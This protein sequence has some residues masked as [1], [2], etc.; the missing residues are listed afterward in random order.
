MKLRY[1]HYLLQQLD[2]LQDPQNPYRQHLTFVGAGAGIGAFYG[3]L[4]TKMIYD[5]PVNYA[6]ANAVDYAV[7]G[8][9]LSLSCTIFHTFKNPLDDDVV[10]WK[11]LK[12]VISLFSALLAIHAVNTIYTPDENIAATEHFKVL[13]K[14]FVQLRQLK[15]AIAAETIVY[16]IGKS[17]S[18]ADSADYDRLKFLVTRD[19][20]PMTPVVIKFVASSGIADEDLNARLQP[21]TLETY[22]DFK[23]AYDCLCNAATN[24]SKV[25]N[26]SLAKEIN[27]FAALVN[28]SRVD[29]KVTIHPL[30]NPE[31]RQS[32]GFGAQQPWPQP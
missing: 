26:G 29:N 9:I 16:Q 27:D 28:Q 13:K 4:N 1:S 2:A 7:K 6:I 31:R 3:S 23:T 18:P 32:R 21:L 22:R 19:A 17:T 30:I 11:I 20:Q 12:S 24:L 14:S 15:Q 5:F 10:N 8:G 25:A